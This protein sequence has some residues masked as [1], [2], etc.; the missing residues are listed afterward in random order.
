MFYIKK[1]KME[2][3]VVLIIRKENHSK[4]LKAYKST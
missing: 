3:K 2:E 1:K 4:A